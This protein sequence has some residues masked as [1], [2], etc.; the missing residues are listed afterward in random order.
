MFIDGS[1][2]YSSIFLSEILGWTFKRE[3]KGDI[4]DI[5]RRVYIKVSGGKNQTWYDVGGEEKL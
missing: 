5:Q 1:K 3:C 2:D 4:L